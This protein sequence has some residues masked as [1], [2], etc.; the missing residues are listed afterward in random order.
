[1][2]LIDVCGELRVLIS[3]CKSANGAKKD[4]AI[5]PCRFSVKLH[6][7][8]CITLWL[9]YLLTFH[10]ML[11]NNPSTIF[12][13]IQLYYYIVVNLIKWRS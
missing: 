8:I 1:M 7:N 9:T 13:L 3:N 10:F 5:L 11:V 2:N 4:K 12:P 6:G